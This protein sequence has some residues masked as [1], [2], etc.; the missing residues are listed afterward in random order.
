MRRKQNSPLP[1]KCGEKYS[2][3]LKQNSPLK[4]KIIQLFSATIL[5]FFL[6]S[7]EKSLKYVTD[8]AVEKEVVNTQELRSSNPC[9]AVYFFKKSGECGGKT[10]FIAK[11]PLT[12]TAF[13]AK[14]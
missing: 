7:Q 9:T 10:F 12:F 4:L 5:T 13:N 3:Q 1:A 2:P 11:K 14:R 8:G 6:N